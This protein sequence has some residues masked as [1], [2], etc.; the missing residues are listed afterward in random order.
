MLPDSNGGNNEPIGLA[1]YVVLS[2]TLSYS[3][4][5]TIIIPSLPDLQKLNI[6]YSYILTIGAL[7]ARMWIP[8]LA[9]ITVSALVHRQKPLRLL[10]DPS[11]KEISYR[12]ALKIATVVLTGYAIASL[13][14]V[15][16]GAHV[17]RCGYYQYLNPTIILGEIALGVTLGVTVNSAVA[18][19]E[20]IGWRGYM[21]TVLRKHYGLIWT[22]VIIGVVW[23]LWHAPLILSG[24][25]YVRLIPGCSAHSGGSISLLVFIIYTTTASIL[26][27]EIREYT[28]SIY[29]SAV[30]HGVING[31][32][33]RMS[34]IVIG[35]PLIAL[36]A[37]LSASL[38]LLF[39]SLFWRWWCHRG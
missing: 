23:G 4:D 17:G 32:A 37:G 21:Y 7:V 12:E 3:L 36:P 25:N 38:G 19:G 1:L 15:A 24:Y 29:S 31:V 18:L 39:A 26:L 20:E 34:I 30:G 22:S 14:S 2:Y 6:G 27:T 35:N 9:V 5:F 8:A 10:R 33:S 28:G 13:I 16:L 11:L